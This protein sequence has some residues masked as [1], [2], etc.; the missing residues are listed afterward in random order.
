MSDLKAKIAEL[1]ERIEAALEAYRKACS[2]ARRLEKLVKDLDAEVKQ[3]QEELN[4][5]PKEAKSATLSNLHECLSEDAY[6]FYRHTL[7]IDLSKKY[8]IINSSGWA[9][10]DDE[11][12]E[13]CMKELE[14]VGLVEKG[15]FTKIGLRIKAHLN[16]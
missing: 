16:S 4:N 15:K 5:Q 8:K 14:K 10:S 7:H 13:R 6:K 3:A 9:T 12:Y 11:R 1:N 2:E